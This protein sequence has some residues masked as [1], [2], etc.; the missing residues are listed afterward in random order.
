MDLVTITGEIL[1][2]KLLFLC[3]VLY[4]VLRGYVVKVKVSV[5]NFKDL[6]K[7]PFSK[8]L[9]QKKKKKK[10][11]QENSMLFM[12]S[13]LLVVSLIDKLIKLQWLEMKFGLLPSKTIV[14]FALMKYL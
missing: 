8:F 13:I 1:H 14:S 7:F 5:D 10:I 6:R 3:S 4:M 12:V 11:E 9:L 2:G